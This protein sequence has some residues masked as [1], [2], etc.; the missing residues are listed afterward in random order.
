MASLSR[1]VNMH[2]L[3]S[4]GGRREGNVLDNNLAPGKIHGREERLTA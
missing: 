1:L 3:G 4:S 2:A